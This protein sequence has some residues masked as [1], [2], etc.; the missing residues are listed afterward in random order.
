MKEASIGQ[1]IDKFTGRIIT[2]HQDLKIVGLCEY[3][4]LLGIIGDRQRA[5]NSYL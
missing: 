5:L 3:V 1:G 2:Y 4:K